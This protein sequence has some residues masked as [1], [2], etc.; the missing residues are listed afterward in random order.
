VPPSVPASSPT[1]PAADEPPG[2]VF[3]GLEGF[4]ERP[5]QKMLYNP[6]LRASVS[7]AFQKGANFDAVM[8]DLNDANLEKQGL[9]VKER[10]VED[11]DGRKTL[12]LKGDRT[13]GQFPQVFTVAMFATKGGCAQLTAIYPADL[14]SEDQQRLD[15]AILNTR[16]ND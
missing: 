9:V 1:P 2:F 13:K 3:Q 12:F 8:A 5:R 11:V 14:P 4:E 15:A 16:Y 7:P 10:K 6:E